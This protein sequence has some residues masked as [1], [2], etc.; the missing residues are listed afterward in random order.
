MTTPWPDVPSL[1]FLRPRRS[2]GGIELDCA[3]LRL[4]LV[5]D[6]YDAVL[7]AEVECCRTERAADDACLDGVATD[8]ARSAVLI[9]RG[10]VTGARRVFDA[11]KAA[12]Q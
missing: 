6:A 7:T 10:K 5:M 11:L 2:V 4:P 8:L 9:A 1:L 3:D 12:V